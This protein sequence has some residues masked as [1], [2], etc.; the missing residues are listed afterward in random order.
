MME[1]E[2]QKSAEIIKKMKKSEIKHDEDKN[3]LI[4]KV[5][6]QLENQWTNKFNK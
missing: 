4:S 3:T 1:M 5:K 2:I 6:K